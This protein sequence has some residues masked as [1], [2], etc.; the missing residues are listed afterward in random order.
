MLLASSSPWYA[1][2]SRS[3]WGGS[4]FYEDDKESER[5]GTGSSEHV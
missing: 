2:R 5:S 1:W 4:G 3:G